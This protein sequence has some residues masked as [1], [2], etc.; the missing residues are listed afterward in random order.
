MK[1]GPAPYRVPSVE[2]VYR[3]KSKIY[4]FVV[5][6]KLFPPDFFVTNGTY[7]VKRFSFTRWDMRDLDLFEYTRAAE[8][9]KWLEVD[10][11]DPEEVYRTGW[12]AR[13]A[14][15]KIVFSRGG[16]TNA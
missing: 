3:T 14:A 2:D 15:I 11:Y 1:H 16:K 13:Q 7:K 6:S 10:I 9:R 12:E 5:G 4:F 8:K